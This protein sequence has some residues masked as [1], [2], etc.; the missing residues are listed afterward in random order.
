MEK[1][2]KQEAERKISIDVHEEPIKGTLFSVFVIG[3]I[4]LITW[5]SV[6]NLFIS[7]L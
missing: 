5:V 6:F 2:T 3:F 1:K 7:R 4:I